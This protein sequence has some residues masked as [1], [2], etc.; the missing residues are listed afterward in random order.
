MTNSLGSSPRLPCGWLWGFGLL[1]AILAGAALRLVY[2][3]DIE[4]KWDERWTYYQVKEYANGGSFPWLGMPSSTGI[5]N[6][7]MS[8]WVF[9]TL[10]KVSPLQDPRDLARAVQVLSVLAIA[11]LAIFAWRAVPLEER[12]P[13]LW[14][15][16]LVSL[17]PFAVLFHR[18]I[19]PPC[20]L[21]IFTIVFLMAWWYR[22]R[23]GWSFVWGLV[24]AC[25]GQI[26][27]AG[28]FF[29]GGFAAWALLFKRR[30]VAWR[31]WL[32]GTS[33]GLIPLIPWLGYVAHARGNPALQAARV[34]HVLE[35]KFW[36]RWV[37]EPF[38]ISLEYALGKDFQDYLGYPL[39]A[40]QRTYLVGFIHALVILTAV[41]LVARAL[42]SFWTNR[43]RMGA[44]ETGNESPT[45][46]TQNAALWGFGI[47]LSASTLPIHRHYL[48][49]LF[50]LTFVWL[51]RLAL[52]RSEQRVSGLHWGRG[53][54][55]ALCILQGCI[56]ATFLEYVHDNYRQIRGDYWI[57]YAAQPNFPDPWKDAA[58]QFR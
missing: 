11:F 37:T 29:T 42:A 45:C 56:S 32:L 20:V 44:L 33:L 17:N 24:G 26:H 52:V 40:G 23:R 14:A 7:G 38:G 22:E 21:P 43:G 3:N 4:Y 49:I 10:S 48:I 35:G 27:M 30:G 8:L 16:A 28:F 54:L 50:P 41:V 12:E 25:L 6:P 2:I 9:L 57:P 53:I 1:A 34:E 55:L 47:L 18:K 39:L 51:A 58:M 46:F 36:M 31:S 5:R 15:A 19:W 13:W